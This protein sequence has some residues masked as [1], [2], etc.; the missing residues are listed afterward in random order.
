MS[1]LTEALERILNW[2]QQNGREQ[3][4]SK[5]LPGL[6]YDEIEELVKDLPIRFPAE[7]Y[8]LYQ[9]RNGSRNDE[10]LYF[11]LQKAVAKYLAQLESYDPS[12]M[13][14][15]DG[16]NWLRICCRMEAKEA[17]Y[18]VISS[19]KETCPVVFLDLKTAGYVRRKYVSLT[20]RMLTFAECLETGVG[21]R[22]ERGYFIWRK[23]NISIVEEA[24]AKLED[25]LS[26]E[27]LSE[28]EGDLTKY[29]DSRA[30]EPL[31]Q[32]LQIPL[33]KISDP[34]ENRAIRQIAARI[35]GEL[36]DS[37]AVEP[38]ICALQDEYWMVRTSAATSLGTLGDLRAVEPLINALQD[39]EQDVRRKAVVS[40]K[41]L[42]AVD[43]LIQALKHNDEWVRLVAAGSL[44]DLK[45]PRAVEH[46]SQLTEDEHEGVRKIATN[47]LERIRRKD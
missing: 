43:P 36:G 45:D 19:N 15:H 28:I 26:I 13:S 11:S 30:V 4:A 34:D 18:L 41:Y 35:L 14:E 21:E 37:R 9:W 17:G 2:W 42:K 47:A 3:A 46:L 24:L 32:A 31:I 16:P 40:L 10:G 33:A 1:A 5:L 7:V 22:D 20:S 6:S 25:N 29:K 39:A 44:G 12:W 27:S 8:E 38:L 23:Y